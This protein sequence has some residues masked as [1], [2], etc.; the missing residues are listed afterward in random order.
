M[1]TIPIE[2][3]VLVGLDAATLEQW[4]LSL[5]TIAANRP[6]LF[7]VPWVVFYD[8]S[9]INNHDIL[10]V[11]DTNGLDRSPNVRLSPWPAGNVA[12]T[13]SSQR[14]RMLAG[15]VHVPRMDISTPWYMKLDTDVIA[16]PHTQWIDSEWFHD[17]PV[18]VAS[19]WGY[20]KVKGDDATAL[21]WCDR[22]EAWGDYS[23][24]EYTRLDLASRVRGDKKIIHKRFWSP[25]SYYNTSWA[26]MIAKLCTEHSGTY[27]MPVPSQDTV[28]WYAAERQCRFYRRVRM[29]KHGW[30]ICSGMRALKSRAREILAE[31]A[32]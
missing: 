22:L 7:T 28:H 23:F 25:I 3:T 32:L 26:S 12:V 17:D 20:T 14:A 4:R 2:L 29:K 24:P 5:P 10:G 15:F 18:L 31:V 30:I 11:I 6:D 16:T 27:Q 8:A 1:T 9:Q 13:Y 21:E 19:P